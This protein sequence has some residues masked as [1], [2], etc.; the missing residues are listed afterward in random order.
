MVTFFG[1]KERKKML[2]VNL[3]KIIKDAGEAEDSC[4]FQLL[5]LEKQIAE[6]K[7]KATTMKQFYVELACEQI[8]GK[9]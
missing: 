9:K 4:Y 8:L 6:I 1:K 3:R 2:N 5:Q 7:R